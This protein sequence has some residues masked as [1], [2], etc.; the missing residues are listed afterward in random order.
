MA[1]GGGEMIFTD[2]DLKRLKAACKASYDEH[3][4]K[5]AEDILAL[6]DRLEAAELCAA[7]LANHNDLG[8]GECAELERWK[9]AAGK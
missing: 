3:K 6:I 9:R 2:Q 7:R 5:D 8:P 4:N 1:Q